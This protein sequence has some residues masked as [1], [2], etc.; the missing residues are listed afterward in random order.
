[1]EVNVEILSSCEIEIQH[2]DRDAGICPG[3]HGW[4]KER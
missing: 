3:V 2:A 4:V 1:M